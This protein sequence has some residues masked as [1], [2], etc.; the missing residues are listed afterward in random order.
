GNTS[1][2]PAQEFALTMGEMIN[3]FMVGLTGGNED[4]A[5]ALGDMMGSMMGS[6]MSGMTG[7]TTAPLQSFTT[8]MSDMMSRFMNDMSSS[9]VSVMDPMI[10]MMDTMMNTMDGN[11]EVIASMFD[12][13][14]G[15]MQSMISQSPLYMQ[16]M[17]T[18]SDDI[19]AM[20]DR[21]GEM[22]DRIVDTQVIQSENFLA[23]QENALLLMNM[24]L[25][26]QESLIAQMGV[27]DFSAM[28]ANLE[29]VDTVISSMNLSE[30]SAESIFASQLYMQTSSGDMI[31]VS[32]SDLMQLDGSVDIT[33][34]LN[35]N[36]LLVGYTIPNATSMNLNDLMRYTTLIQGG[37]FDMSGL[38]M[39]DLST[40]S[41]S[42]T[43]MS[44]MMSSMIGMFM[45]S[46]FTQSDSIDASMMDP[47]MAM[48]ESFMGGMD[49][50]P[51]DEFSVMMQ[52]MMG[53]MSQS[54]MT[55]S[56]M[57]MSDSMMGMMS[58]SL[59]AMPLD[60][61]NAM[62]STMMQ[63]FGNS[64]SVGDTPMDAMAYTMGSMMLSFMEGMTGAEGDMAAHEFA[65]TMGEMMH[66]FMVGVTGSRD[67]P[68]A[69]MGEMMGSMMGAFMTSVTGDA[70]DP[71][72]T[73]MDVMTTMMTRFMNDFSSSAAQVMEPMADVMQVMLIGIQGNTDYISSMFAMMNET[74]Q[75]M[76]EM[77]PEYM[78]T[79]L[80]LS[81][82]IGLMADRI[83]EMAD[84][85]V[86]TEV[87][88]SANFLAT[89]Q[90]TMELI[91]MLSEDSSYE[92]M[93]G[94]S[95]SMVMDNLL[96]L[97]SAMDDVSSMSSMTT[98]VPSDLYL[99]N[100]F[101]EIVKMSESELY[102]SDGS[103]SIAPFLENNTML[104]GYT[105]PLGSSMTLPELL[106]MTQMVEGSGFTLEQLPMFADATSIMDIN[107]FM[108]S[109]F[110]ADSLS[111]MDLPLDQF[112][113]M[114]QGFESHLGSEASP[115]EMMG[116]TMGSMMYAFMSGMTQ[117]DTAQTPLEFAELMGEMVREFMI[118]VTGEESAPAGAMGEMMGSMMG[119]FMASITGDELTPMSSFTQTM[120]G[121]FTR[122]A[123]TA[124]ANILTMM[125]PAHDLMATF[126]D[127]M[128]ANMELFVSMFNT[129]NG[130]IEELIEQ[131]PLY[132]DTMLRLS[133]DIGLMAGRINEMADRI[134]DTQVI[135]SENFLATQT[136]AMELMSILNEN[137]QFLSEMMGSD[138]FTGMMESLTGAVDTLDTIAASSEP[139]TYT[140]T[141]YI[142]GADGALIA[143]SSA[144][145]MAE[146]GLSSDISSLLDGATLLV[147]YT[148]PTSSMMSM[149]ELINATQMMDS[150]TSIASLPVFASDM[151]IDMTD[152]IE[153]MMNM[154]MGSAMGLSMQESVSEPFMEIMESFVAGMGLS[155]EQF[156]GMFHA[157]MDTM[158]IND[159][160]RTM[161]EMAEETM[162]MLHM[163]EFFEP[164]Q[165]V[166]MM[167]DTFMADGTPMATMADMMGSMMQSFMGEI[168][169]L[170]AN[171]TPSEMAYSM[172]E[173]VKAFMS[174]VTA[175][176]ENPALA[177]GEMMGS[178]MGAFMDSIVGEEEEFSVVMESMM[179]QMS[180]TIMTSI[181][182]ISEPM[183]E[184]F[185][186]LGDGMDETI[187]QMHSVMQTAND[188]M[189]LMMDQSDVFVGA[190]TS[191]SE[192]VIQ[193]AQ[194]VEDMMGRVDE[195]IA[196]QTENFMA[197][198]QNL[199]TFIEMLSSSESSA[200]SD[201][202][203]NLET[204][205]TLLDETL[206]TDYLLYGAFEPEPIMEMSFM[207][208]SYEP[209]SEDACDTL[210]LE[211]IMVLDGDLCPLPE[212]A[213][214]VS[215]GSSAT[216][217]SY[218]PEACYDPTVLVAVT[219][220]DLQHVV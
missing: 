132:L 189:G 38:P 119:S 88:Q 21:I 200:M 133:D 187:A 175:D 101:G 60:S 37:G 56:M 32:E 71:L 9:M 24:L 122:L 157:M 89:Q 17:L 5:Q 143:L 172:G 29:K 158:M 215:E 61:F 121:S 54:G 15:T 57:Q 190:M 202:L 212:C 180:A 138:A 198:Q 204:A 53:V 55:D 144:Q 181:S 130:T 11:M 195:T 23:T 84:R 107:S 120:M 136:N 217:T 151:Q 20:A 94:E 192:D 90:N 70:E 113:Q 111:M 8:T 72:G 186:S 183:N 41:A 26:N 152:M 19:G 35:G 95:F 87:I 219:P 96:K 65:R 103:V 114:I 105:I 170:G 83:G 112:N 14:N 128:D 2:K 108:G 81:D 30:L 208:A 166:A 98:V 196:L 117:S 140:S 99:L 59:S 139:Q 159:M 79:I 167:M 131:T 28:M 127:G 134:V 58:G 75:D 50:M 135:M 145:L 115:M 142:Q 193:M 67:E 141:L 76:I 36:Q 77:S 82:D 1:E 179:E 137:S 86:E 102:N 160:M 156:E 197:T 161:M 46:G 45:G 209:T 199:N 203:Q 47:F 153:S 33:Q 80:R 169:G 126:V 22:A 177:M 16:T 10:S 171:A 97:Q 207:T 205:Q 124:T 40:G 44:S 51:M 220:D 91:T 147:G 164:S 104:V 213:T 49:S 182:E 194:S 64:M 162:A 31:A 92:Q 218:A 68:A 191:L 73:F 176:Q 211:G 34:F 48:M 178:M 110:S 210:T 206:G 100:D 149:S 13:A 188:T 123:D 85:I 12:T 74:A 109:M 6:M 7:D 62:M 25:Q 129:A 69:A 118:G 155:M 154:M 165:M 174:G 148:I 184:L 39:F 93:M 216:Q 125:D 163:D 66:Q 168:S 4:P 150:S 201:V 106:S 146:D 27:E 43:D 63:S 52:E 18:L 214:E 173:M 185:L 116:Q 78:A 42:I 3:Q